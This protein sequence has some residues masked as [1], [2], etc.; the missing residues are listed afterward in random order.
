MPE[1]TRLEQLSVRMPCCQQ[2]VRLEVGVTLVTDAGPDQAV[3]AAD[4]LALRRA[5][6][7]HL[8]TCPKAD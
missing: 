1:A 5:V 6:R 4:M 8:R 2:Q 3:V 7:V